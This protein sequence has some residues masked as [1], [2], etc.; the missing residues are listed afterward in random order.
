VIEVHFATLNEIRWIGVDL[1][2]TGHVAVAADPLS[3]KILKLGKSIHYT[4]THSVNNCTKFWKEGKLWKLKKLKTR[5][6]KS[7]KAA[8][9]A[10]TRQIVTFAESMG[11]GIKFEKLF[12]NHYARHEQNVRVYEFTFDNGS[13]FTLQKMVEQRA[14]NRG[15]PVMYVNP[16]FTSKRCCRCGEFG[17]RFRKRFECPHCGYVVHADVN[18]AFNIATTPIR[19]ATLELFAAEEDRA[20]LLSKK[21]MRRMAKAEARRRPVPSPAP[22]VAAIT[23]IAVKEN[24]L[25]VLEL[26]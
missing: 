20:F 26:G 18:A 14:H 13:F 17:R 6:R 22:G 4:H 24:L 2:T 9:A 25:A 21:Q 8:L 5:E 12:S 11:T 16:A 15:I 10:I 7:F 23:G 3:G 19:C 1:N